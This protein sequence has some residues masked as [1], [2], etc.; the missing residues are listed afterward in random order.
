LSS[1]RVKGWRIFATDMMNV[2]PV[3]SS[4]TTSGAETIEGG[5]NVGPPLTLRYCR[6]VQAVSVDRGVGVGRIGR[7]AAAD[8]PP[9]LAMRLDAL[10]KKLHVRAEDEVAGE[11]PVCEVELVLRGP[12]V[13]AGAVS[14]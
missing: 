12:H 14:V 1:V 7:Q 8:D 6:E 11:L 5:W 9:Q 3:R 10:P 2:L 13:R 4:C